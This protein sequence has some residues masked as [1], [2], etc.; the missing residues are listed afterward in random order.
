MI[1]LPAID[2]R[3]GRCVRLFQGDYARETVYSDSP[4]DQAAQWEAQGGKFLH[5]V[6]L[7][8]AKEGKVV[9][10]E[11]IR[12]ICG[13]VSIPCE[14]GG[15][16]RTLAD[17]EAAFEL[18]VSR[19]ILGTAACESPKIVE[20]FIREFGADRVVAGID[21]KN[22]KVA[23]RGWLET[24]EVS[25]QVLAKNM[26]LLGVNRIIFTDIATDGTLT[27]PNFNAIREL[28]EMLP[29]CSIVASGGIST[30]EDV[31]KFASF[32]LN[33]LEGAIVGKALYDGRVTLAELNKAAE[34]ACH[35]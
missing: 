23:L 22:G 19:V 8:G 35:A 9:N 17:A 20:D 18:G 7:D 31:A 33:N 14:L 21:A 29:D 24:S 5:L 32:G 2:L 28:C 3:G 1:I 25:A 34:G 15:G 12:S 30:V 16:I 10:G 13:R 26:Y 11:A 4:A 6:D 27:G